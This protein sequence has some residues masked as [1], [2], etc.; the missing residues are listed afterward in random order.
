MRSKLAALA[1][2]F[3]FAA[4]L[5]S[6]L[7]AGDGFEL[8]GY[9]GTSFPGYSQTFT[10]D[11]GPVSVPI[12]G[13]S[14]TQSGSFDL[15]ASGGLVFAGGATLYFG[16]VVGI[17]GRLDW[18]DAGLESRGQRY[19][20]SVTLPGVPQPVTAA[21]DL[22]VGMV[23]LD[24]FRPWSVNLKIRTPGSVRFMVSGGISRRPDLAFTVEQRIGLGASTLDVPDLELDVSTVVLEGM[25]VPDEEDASRWGFNLGGGL[26]FRIGEN[27]SLVAEAR[28]FYFK[29]QTFSWSATVPDRTLSEIEQ[30]LLDA[31]LERLPPVEFE[32]QFFLVT[33]GLAI[34][35]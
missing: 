21:L 1:L 33:G 28:Y 12:P 15:D 22:G 26:Q 19:D 24:T 11:P 35:F 20:V 16:G 2:A 5:P 25:L 17:E 14:V 7:S 8:A 32:P 13:V 30:M 4:L 27:V 18:V 10:Y 29:K 6:P 34:N 23:D 9:L 31:T 3:A